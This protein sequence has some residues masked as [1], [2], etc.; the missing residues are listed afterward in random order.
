MVNEKSNKKTV[1]TVIKM[2]FTF[3][4]MYVNQIELPNWNGNYVSQD[5]KRKQKAEKSVV[6]NKRVHKLIERKN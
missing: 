2:K 5:K 3:L 4:S 6:S 1:R